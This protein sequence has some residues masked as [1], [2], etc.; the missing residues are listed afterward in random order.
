MNIR[1]RVYFP[2][3]AKSKKYITCWNVYKIKFQAHLNR[4]I[5]RWNRASVQ[6]PFQCVEYQSRTLLSS[7]ATAGAGIFEFASMSMGSNPEAL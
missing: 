4:L 1:S 6:I 3:L 5:Q 7:A 2:F